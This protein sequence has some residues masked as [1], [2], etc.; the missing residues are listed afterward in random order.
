[1]LRQNR[2]R[3][4]REHQSESRCKGTNAGRAGARETDAEN[5]KRGDRDYRFRRS[6]LEKFKVVHVR[7]ARFSF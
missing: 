1:L 3:A 7:M 6:E 4:N 5:S 2:Y